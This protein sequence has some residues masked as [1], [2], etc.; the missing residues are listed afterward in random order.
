MGEFH[1][2]KVLS[3]IRTTDKILTLWVVQGNNEIPLLAGQ[4]CEQWKGVGLLQLGRTIFHTLCNCTYTL[5]FLLLM[6][7]L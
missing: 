6:K 4:V 3:P 1:E 2:L 5:T 7:I